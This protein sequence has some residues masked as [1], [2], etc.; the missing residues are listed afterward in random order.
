MRIST[1]DKLVVTT[2][3]GALKMSSAGPRPRWIKVLLDW[4]GQGARLLHVV[5]LK[6]GWRV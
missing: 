1:E 4:W 2:D 5:Y 6:A 3:C